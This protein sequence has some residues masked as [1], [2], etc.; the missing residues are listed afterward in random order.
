M[1]LFD[2]Q[3]TI[4]F[5]KSM[6]PY[7]QAE[8][9]NSKDGR[10]FVKSLYSHAS[11]DSVDALV[12]ALG[13]VELEKHISLSEVAFY[14]PTQID[15]PQDRTG[16]MTTYPDKRLNSDH[17]YRAVGANI[18]MP[19]QYWTQQADLCEMFGA[20]P[21]SIE[22]ALFSHVGEGRIA[23]ESTDKQMLFARL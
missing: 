19:Q 5:L 21:E 11:K 14:N 9:L 6:K 22:A 17:V 12:K 18:M 23:Y 1:E 3:T 20:S 16:K 4:T 15:V 8:Y 2:L 7:K 10:E 13:G